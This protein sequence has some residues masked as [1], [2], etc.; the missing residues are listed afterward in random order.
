MVLVNEV[1]QPHQSST[2]VPQLSNP[3]PIHQATCCTAI[4][5]EVNLHAFLKHMAQRSFQQD[6][7]ACG[8]HTGNVL[9]LC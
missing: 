9:S 2:D 7:I 8:T 6:A 5:K 1:L 3:T 4:R